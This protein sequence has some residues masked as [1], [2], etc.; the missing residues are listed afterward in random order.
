MTRYIMRFRTLP[1]LVRGA[2]M[3]SVAAVI[4][5]AAHALAEPCAGDCNGDGMVT[6]DELITA[7]NVDLGKAPADACPAGTCNTVDCL[8]H[9]IDNILYGCGA[10]CGPV[11]CAAGQSCCNP[12]LGICV[13]PDEPACIQ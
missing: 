11:V 13:S 2:C 4:L 5:I 1:F 9:I 8:V 6:I 7:V 10:P 12:L 3:A